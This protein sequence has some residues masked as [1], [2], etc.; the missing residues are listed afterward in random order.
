MMTRNATVFAI[1]EAINE[2][3][4]LI[5]NIE[6]SV[7]ATAMDPVLE[8]LEQAAELA[9]EVADTLDDLPDEYEEE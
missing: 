7:L 2:A 1:Q 5:N 9:E 6:D 3:K 8:L 4:Y